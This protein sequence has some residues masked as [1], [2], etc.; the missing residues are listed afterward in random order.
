MH[1]YVA[2]TNSNMRTGSQNKYMQ[3]DLNSKLKLLGITKLERELGFRKR[4]TGKIRLQALVESFYKSCFRSKF[5]LS[6][7]AFQLSAQEGLCISKQ[8]VFYRVNSSLTKL[9]ERL[10]NNA[11]V[12]Q[13]KPSQ[14]SQNSR[15]KNVYIQDGMAIKLPD[16]L[17]TKYKGNYSRGK[18]KAVA[19]LQVIYNASK[20]NFKSILLTPFTRNDQTA[21]S[22]ILPLLKKGD[23]VIRDMGYFVMPTFR[24][25]VQRKADFISRYKKDVAII[26]LKSKQAVSIIQLL[27]G[28]T[29]LKRK[30]ILGAKEQLECTLIAVKVAPCLAEARR[31][32]AMKDRDKRLRY[33]QDKKILLGWDIY[34]SS[35]HDLDVK[36]VQDYYA[37]RWQIE[38]I[39]K[40]WKSGL[41]L[42]KSIPGQLNYDHLA[43]TVI[44]L[45][46]LLIVLMIT[47]IYNTLKSLI[48][49]PEDRVSLLKSVKI[50]L[51]MIINNRIQFDLNVASKLANFTLYEVRNRD[52]MVDKLRIL[53]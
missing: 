8:A 45:H 21:S 9:L 7:W 47:P 33:T 28:K 39:F 24:Q 16:N 18:I 52:T 22:D 40:S 17:S 14:T 35:S 19:K 30:V 37:A 1:N 11:L 29:V 53:A 23:L 49:R 6:S 15:F 12:A 25:I 4:R 41:S 38:I 5:S 20:R 43:V 27:R 42:E 10:L 3:H 34:L 36:D 26:D 2:L 50:I 32:K 48:R 51:M 46:L 31:R 13:I 44:Y